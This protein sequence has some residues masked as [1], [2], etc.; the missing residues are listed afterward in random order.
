[1]LDAYFHRNDRLA[2][3]E[4]EGFHNRSACHQNCGEVDFGAGRLESAAR[5]ALPAARV[6]SQVL[7]RSRWWGSPWPLYTCKICL[8]L[9]VLFISAIGIATGQQA[10]PLVAP[11]ATP[12]LLGAGDVIDVKFT[13]NPELDTRVTVRPD[14]AISMA[15]VGDIAAQGLSPSGLAQEITSRYAP[16]RTHPEAI[17]I[18]VEFASQRV[19]VGGEVNGPGVVSLRGALSG[20]QALLNAGGP[21]TSARLDNVILLRYVGNNTAEVRTL[22]MTQVMRGKNPDVVLQPYDVLY[23]PRTKIARVGLFVEQYVNNLVPRA[24][25]FPYNLNNVFT[26]SGATH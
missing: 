24:L 19:Y 14:G 3:E 26:L 4:P 16:F 13:Y 15:I 23:V 20:F 12:Y 11:S 1:M 17:V 10:P 5:P 6:R 7:N 8:P 9:I 25:L 18:V 2:V 22:N 21:K